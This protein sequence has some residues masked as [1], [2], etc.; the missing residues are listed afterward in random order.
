M[1]G[2]R[3]REVFAAQVGDVN[4]K[5]WTVKIRGTK[6]DLAAGT[7]P[8]PTLMRALHKHTGA[9]TYAPWGNARRD[10]ALYCVKA[11][12]PVVTWNDL[13]RTFASLLVQAGVAPHLVAKLLRHK[14]TAMVDRVYGRQTGESLAGLIEHQIAGSRREPRVNQKVPTK[15][16]SGHTKPTRNK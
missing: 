1:T 11:G 2:A 13:R 14:T 10:L 16:G 3:R 7:I 15:A 9:G 12:V 4:A 6:T 5:A 8:I